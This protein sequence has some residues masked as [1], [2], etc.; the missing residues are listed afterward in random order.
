MDIRKAAVLGAGTMGAGIAA[1]LSNAGIPTLLLDIAPRELTPDEEKK[2]LTLPGYKSGVTSL[3]FS[4]DEKF[5]ASGGKDG[6]VRIFVTGEATGATIPKNGETVLALTFSREGRKLTTAYG[7]GPKSAKV[8]LSEIITAKDGDTLL[9]ATVDAVHVW[10]KQGKSME[11]VGT[12][13]RSTEPITALALSH[14]SRFALSCG[15]DNL[16]R[17]WDVSTLKQVRVFAAAQHVIRSLAFSSDGS[18]AVSGDDGSEVRLW[19]IEP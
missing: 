6:I 16:I 11:V 13:S 17:L 18:H 10:R 19:K 2:G 5:L 8:L 9:A 4:S 1:H 14:D 7:D 15:G 3:A 12:F